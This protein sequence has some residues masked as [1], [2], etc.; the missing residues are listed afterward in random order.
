M[1]GKGWECVH[2]IGRGE[3][4][5]VMGKGYPRVRLRGKRREGD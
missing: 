2:G 1:G 5:W 4:M 3:M